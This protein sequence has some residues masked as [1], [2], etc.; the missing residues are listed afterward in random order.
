M[1]E[2]DGVVSTGGVELHLTNSSGTLTK[3]LGVLTLN[4]P[5][6]MIDD[7]E[8]TDQDDGGVKDYKPSMGDYPELQ[9]TLKHEPG[10][11]THQLILE[12]LA[13]KEKRPCKIIVVKED[14]TRQE[15]A[16]VIFLKTYVPDNAGLGNRREATLTGRVR[17]FA[18]SDEVV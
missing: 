9:A 3:L 16:G 2:G 12:H 14:D 4:A 10:S 13:S 17:G 8:T 11:A 7:A 5:S 6:L 18:R 15:G 1:A